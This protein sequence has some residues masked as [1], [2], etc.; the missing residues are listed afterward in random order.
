M[1]GTNSYVECSDDKFYSEI[2]R[3]LIVAVLANEKQAV[4][5]ILKNNVNCNPIRKK[6]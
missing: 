5:A 3:A 4:E 6:L 2:D 1:R